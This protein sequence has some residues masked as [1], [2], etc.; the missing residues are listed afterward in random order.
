MRKLNG[1]V[2]MHSTPYFVWANFPLERLPREKLTSPIFFLPMLFEAA[3]AEVTPYYALLTLLHDRIT[4]MRSGKYVERGGGT[5]QES[6]LS[7]PAKRLLRDYRMVQ[8][9]LSVG[10]RHAAE[11]LLGE[12]PGTATSSQLEALTKATP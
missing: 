8:Y 4:A 1:A 6:E 3:D 9:D 10:P 7:P 5:V 11:A 2:A 12:V